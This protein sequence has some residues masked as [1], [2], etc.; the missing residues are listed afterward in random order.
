MKVV[1]LLPSATEIVYALGLEPVGVSHA[2]DW[3]P[4]ATEIPAVNSSYINP[5]TDTEEINQQVVQAEREH[6]G[7][8]EIDLETLSEL[9]PDLII[10]QGVCDVCAVDQ[11]LVNDVV[12]Q[13]NLDTE[14]LT[15]DSHTLAGIFDDIRTIGTAIGRRDQA[16][17]LIGGLRARVKAVETET[18][19][20]DHRPSVAVFDWTDPVMIAGH[21]VPELVEL[22]GGKYGLAGAGDRSTVREWDE[23]LEYDPEVLIISP[24]GFEL[25]QTL[26]NL[27]D[28][29]ERDGWD[30]LSAVQSGQVYLM[31]GH[32]YMNRPGPRIVD[33][34]EYLTGLIQPT[35][36]DEP[37][38]HVARTP[39]STKTTA[40]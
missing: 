27:H 40:E 26:D 38:E 8:Y 30:D 35:V 14:V 34:L 25:E 36:V 18:A 3:P 2:C 20:T 16:E 13:L 29:L 11:V 12:T 17:E 10:T 9:D 15:L 23:I 32:N 31:D 19:L 28:L 4:G 24:C 37:P 6:G 1:S 7:V 21:W 5:E 22:A 39:S 33:T